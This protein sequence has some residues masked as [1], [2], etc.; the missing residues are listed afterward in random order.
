MGFA[1]LLD[2]NEALVLLDNRMG[3]FWGG[4][5]EKRR[6]LNWKEKELWRQKRKK[7]MERKEEREER[8]LVTLE[9]SR[10]TLTYDIFD[11]NLLQMA[12]NS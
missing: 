8:A 11:T 2:G 4:M 7:E 1:C 10:T 12:S 9:L 3:W 5:K 6:G